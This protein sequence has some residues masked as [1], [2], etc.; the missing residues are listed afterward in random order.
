[1]GRAPVQRQAGPGHG[2]LAGDQGHAARGRN[3]AA[4]CRGAGDHRGVP[5]PGR[6]YA[7]VDERVAGGGV[8]LDS[9]HGRLGGKPV[10]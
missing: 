1:A 4:H 6:F 5:V 2:P 10:P 7:A 3:D 8:H 9:V